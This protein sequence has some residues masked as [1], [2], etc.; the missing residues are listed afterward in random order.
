M[1]LADQLA[2]AVV[3]C[4]GMA[5]CLV[6]D[7]TSPQFFQFCQD[8]P[9]FRG[10]ELNG[11]RRTGVL[12]QM[13][14]IHVHV[15]EIALHDETEVARRV[16]DG[17]EEESIEGLEVLREAHLQCGFYDGADEGAKTRIGVLNIQAV[18]SAAEPDG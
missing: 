11:C 1:E 2:I 4:N 12:R 14:E 9:I 13:N 3:E 16:T 18:S 7:L 8:P 15:G 17:G 5:D 10:Q 6:A